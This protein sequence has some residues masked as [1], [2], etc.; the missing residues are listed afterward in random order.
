MQKKQSNIIVN[1][2]YILYI[3]LKDYIFNYNILCLIEKLV[4]LQQDI[5]K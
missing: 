3:Y 5:A 1:I 2:F 4:S